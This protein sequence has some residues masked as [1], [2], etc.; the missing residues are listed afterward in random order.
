MQISEAWYALH[1]I[2]E[3]EWVHSLITIAAMT[4]KFIPNTPLL[5]SYQ[6]IKV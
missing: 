1:A 4:F 5:C 6:D 3:M 2:A